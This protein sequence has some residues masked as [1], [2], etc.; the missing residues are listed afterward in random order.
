LRFTPV[1][2]LAAVALIAAKA[3]AI[4]TP[5][6]WQRFKWGMSR[7]ELESVDKDARENTGPDA[8]RWQEIGAYAA[9]DYRFDAKFGFTAQGLDHISLDL[10]DASSDACRKLNAD[11]ERKYGTGADGPGEL[12]EIRAWDLPQTNTHVAYIAVGETCSVDYSR[13]KSDSVEGL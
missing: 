7:A 1:I 6:G 9:G 2:C 8:A 4:H 12:S 3:P 11:L 13:L 5:G 10:K